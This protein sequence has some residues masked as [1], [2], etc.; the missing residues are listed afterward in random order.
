MGNRLAGKVAIVTGAG[1]GIGRAE[2]LLLASEGASVVVNDLG[3]AADGSGSD[4]S[5]AEQVVAEIEAA[6]G[7]AVANHGSVMSWDDSKA[8]V[9]QAVEIFGGLDIVINNA[10]ILRDKMSFNM[11]EDER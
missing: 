8:M 4:A 11:D 7:A 3:G 9:D 10:G 5:A 1:R 6:G 2:A